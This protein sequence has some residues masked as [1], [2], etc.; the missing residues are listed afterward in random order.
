TSGGSKFLILP[1]PTPKSAVG[2][3]EGERSPSVLASLKAA[4]LEAQAKASAQPC[5]K[6]L[7]LGSTRWRAEYESLN[8]HDPEEKKDSDR[9]YD[10][11]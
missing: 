3:M 1:S 11:L 5:K 7:Y 6:S 8:G 10:F 2:L 9:P 4:M